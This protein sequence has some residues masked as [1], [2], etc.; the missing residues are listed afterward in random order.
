MGLTSTYKPEFAIEID[1]QPIPA[2]MR[3]SISSIT[4]TDG[5][6]GADRVEVTLAN[7]SLQFLED[8]LLVVDN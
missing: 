3:G 6:E 7:T 5:M 1:G 2:A 4:Y 8:P